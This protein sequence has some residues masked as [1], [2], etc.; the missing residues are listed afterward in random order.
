MRVYLDRTDCNLVARTTDKDSAIV[1]ENDAEFEAFIDPIRA[2]NLYF[3]LRRALLDLLPYQ[4]Y[5][6]EGQI[7]KVEAFQENL[8]K[9]ISIG[10]R[11]QPPDVPLGDG[12]PKQESK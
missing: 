5:D 4:C 1:V 11:P 3:S 12:S 9:E 7:A 8:R 10:E 2:M 6:D